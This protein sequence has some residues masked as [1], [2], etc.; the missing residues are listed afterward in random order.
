[1]TSFF[2]QPAYII[3]LFSPEVGLDPRGQ[4]R[5]LE[6]RLAS[7]HLLCVASHLLPG[8]GNV[9]GSNRSTQQA[10]GLKKRQGEEAGMWFWRQINTLNCARN[11]LKRLSGETRMP[12]AKRENQRKIHLKRNLL[13][14]LAARAQ[15][16][17]YF[18]WSP[19]HCGFLHY[20]K[21]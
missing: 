17:S 14:P 16:Q 10:R 13:L 7:R 1:M 3:S 19:F 8:E 15:W 5:P 12:S 4:V 20:F 2:S 11:K 21:H 6:R 9:F 18:L